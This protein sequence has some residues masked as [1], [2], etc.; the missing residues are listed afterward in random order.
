MFSPQL[1]KCVMRQAVLSSCLVLVF[2]LCFAGNSWAQ[3]AIDT[4]FAGFGARAVGMGSAFIGLAD[5]ASASE[6]N[7]AGLYHLERPEIIFE[8]SYTVD[9]N[10]GHYLSYDNGVL[11]GKSPRREGSG[12]WTPPFVSLAYPLERV[13]LSISRSSPIHFKRHLNTGARRADFTNYGLSAAIA[14]HPKLYLGTTLKYGKFHFRQSER[15]GS[16]STSSSFR[17][18]SLGVNFGVLWKANPKF[19]LGAVYKSSQRMSGRYGTM[20]VHIKIPRAVGIGAA[21]SPNDRWRLVA[22]VEHVKWSEFIRGREN[23]GFERDD[24]Y[25]YH[26]GAEYLLGIWGRDNPTAV[27]LRG[28]GMREESKYHYR[29]ISTSGRSFSRTDALDHFSSGLGVAREGYQLDF[30]VDHS[31]EATRFILSTIIYF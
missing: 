20:R 29:D 5:D 21:Y 4:E 15:T 16:G 2:L 19:S 26:I 28:G 9:R 31:S 3:I 30:A 25:R 1:E 10:R 23:M 12:Y 22:D 24:G 7:P 14:P 8:T 18:N 6:Y 13:V 11:E 17:G 27:F